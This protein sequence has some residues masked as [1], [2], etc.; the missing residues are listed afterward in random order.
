MTATAHA[1]VGGAIAATVS[2]PAIGLPL[3][4]ISHPL[5]DMIPHW[6]FG[7]GWRKKTKFKLFVQASFDLLF[8]LLISYLI[9][10]QFMDNKIY[11]LAAVFLSELMDIMEIPYWFMGWNFPPFSTMYKFQ[12]HIQGKAKLPWGILTQVATVAS[13][14]LV[15][16]SLF[17][18]T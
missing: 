3:A 9:F 1:L 6:D 14:V 5:I 13:I 16:N 12:S 4:L 8:G 11:F 7:W 15:L 18:T 2:N 10:G 17:K